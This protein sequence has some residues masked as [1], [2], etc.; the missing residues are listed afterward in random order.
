MVLERMSGAAKY[1]EEDDYVA[2]SDSL[3]G[4]DLNVKMKRFIGSRHRYLICSA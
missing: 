4:E 1:D 3:C 2:R